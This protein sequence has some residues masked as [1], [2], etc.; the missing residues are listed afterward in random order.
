[1]CCTSLGSYF[2]SGAQEQTP[3][4]SRKDVLVYTGGPLTSDLTVVGPVTVTLWAKSS[5]RDTDFTVKLVDVQPNGFAYNVLDRVVRTRFR[6]GSKAAPSLVEP[7][8]PAEYKLEL[9]YTATVFKVGHRLRLD[10]SSSKFPQLARNP[11]TGTDPA[12]ESH[13]QTA[14]QT[15]LHDAEHPSRVELSVVPNA[16]SQ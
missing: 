11:N 13:L 5:A 12:T 7:N 6:N 3:I 16:K 14:V 9:G 1:L 15:V 2:G 4:E 10:I 8:T